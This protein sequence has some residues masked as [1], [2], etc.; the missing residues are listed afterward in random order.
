ME[1]CIHSQTN[2]MLG[3]STG[4][5]YA[6]ENERGKSLV[7]DKYVMAAHGKAER[8]WPFIACSESA[9]T[10]VSVSYGPPL[11]FYTC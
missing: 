8:E 9:F 2:K 4:R 1:S 10:E 3:F 11:K 5:P 6:I 7:V